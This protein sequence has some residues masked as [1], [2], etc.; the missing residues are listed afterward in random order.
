VKRG[1]AAELR[2]AWDKARLGAPGLGGCETSGLFEHPA[3]C[4]PVIPDVRT[5]NLPPCHNSF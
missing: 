4:S 1:S 3:R 5:I 2:P